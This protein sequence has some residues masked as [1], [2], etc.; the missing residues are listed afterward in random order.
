MVDFDDFEARS[1]AERLRKEAIEAKANEIR[2]IKLKNL[3]EQIADSETE[4]NDCITQM[5]N[6]FRILVPDLGVPENNQDSVSTC[7]EDLR[8]HGLT[9]PNFCLVI[10]V[11][12][13]HVKLDSDNRDV[14]QSLHD[15]YKLLT[16]RYLPTVMKW[17]V[18]AGKLNA[19]EDFQKLILD[20][21]SKMETLVTKYQELKLPQVF[22]AQDVSSESDSDLESV[23]DKDGYEETIQDPPPVPAP[24]SST[25]IMECCSIQVANLPG[26][27]GHGVS[28]KGKSLALKSSRIP[29]DIDEYSSRQSVIQAPTLSM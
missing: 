2:K 16:N 4:M 9:N 8:E 25:E 21:K 5:D 20:L 19:E 11:K 29:T 15:Q 7:T 13:V 12:D 28:R 18:S 22:R 24:R 26:P 14:V 23:I 17:N 6:G 10:E 1:A 27:S 3:T